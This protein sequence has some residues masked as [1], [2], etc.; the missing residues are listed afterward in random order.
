MSSLQSLGRAPEVSRLWTRGMPSVMERRISCAWIL[1]LTGRPFEAGSRSSQT[2]RHSAR[3]AN[4][5]VKSVIVRLYCATRIATHSVNM[6]P[7]GSA[8]IASSPQAHCPPLKSI[9]TRLLLC[10]Q[11]CFACGPALFACQTWEMGHS[12]NLPTHR[13]CSSSIL[14]S[15]QGISEWPGRETFCFSANWSNTPHFTPW[16]LWVAAN[17]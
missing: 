4:C 12:P 13:H 2:I 3:R 7:P 11:I 17:G 16:S 9:V 5:P 10:A 6:M 15:C 1:P 14:I 8:K